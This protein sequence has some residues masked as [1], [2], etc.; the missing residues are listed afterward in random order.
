MGLGISLLV[1]RLLPAEPDLADALDRLAPHR[2]RPP[3]A[4]T[5]AGSGKERLGLWALRVLPSELWVRTPARE[6]ALLRM[7][8]AKFYGEKLAFAALGLFI[9]PLLAFFFSLLG[10]GLPV[11]THMPLLGR[12]C[13][14]GVRLSAR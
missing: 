4:A 10:L 7:S 13:R 1:V 11:A 2:A 3:A 8:L 6:L 14:D 12:L 5:A 9:A